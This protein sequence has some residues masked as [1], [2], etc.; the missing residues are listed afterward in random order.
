MAIAVPQIRPR[1]RPSQTPSDPRG[2]RN[3]R[4]PQRRGRPG[5]RGEPALPVPLDRARGGGDARLRDG[6]RGQHEAR[7]LA[8]LPAPGLT[9]GPWF[10]R[11]RRFFPLLVIVALAV[12]VALLLAVR[13]SSAPTAAP[14]IASG[15]AEAAAKLPPPWKIRVD[16]FNGTTTP[17]AA[18][19]LSDQIGGPLAYRLGKVANANRSDYVETRVYFPPGADAIA[20]RLAKQLG[21]QATALP[22]GKDKLRL[23]VVIGSDRA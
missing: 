9:V 12:A 13:P 11:T 14:P 3:A 20:A 2:G 10:A 18:A 1:S 19:E 4:T 7:E 5:A 16:V 6:A 22:G 21:V 8:G 15:S 23:V 17:N